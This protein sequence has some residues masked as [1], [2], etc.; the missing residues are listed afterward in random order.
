[1]SAKLSIK[2]RY[3][4]FICLVLVLL[5]GFAMP[6]PKVIP[7]SGA[8]SSDW[9]KDTF[10]FEPWGSSGVHKGID[11]FASK[12]TNVIASS[13]MLVIYRGSINKGGNVV[14]GLGPKWRIHYFSHLDNINS[15]AGLFLGVGDTLGQVGD[16]GNAKG[17][18]PHLH[19]SILSILPRV[20][21]IDSDVQGYKKAFYIN[22]IHYLEN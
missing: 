5:F 3:K 18:P 15:D 14:V 11:I 13:N 10:W 20:W 9:N 2:K 22:P 21:A 8:T 16:S 17:K 1:M 12:G 19:F 4:I 7:V 6:E